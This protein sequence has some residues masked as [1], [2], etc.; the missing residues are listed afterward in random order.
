MRI[1]IPFPGLYPCGSVKA[2]PI[3]YLLTHTCVCGEDNFHDDRKSAHAEL[4]G[5][6][7]APHEHII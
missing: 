5:F 3:L 1:V 4:F 6:Y 2:L 7:R